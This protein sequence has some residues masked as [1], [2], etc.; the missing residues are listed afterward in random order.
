MTQV[1]RNTR[2]R[3]KKREFLSSTARAGSEP[4]HLV[5]WGIAGGAP[6]LFWRFEWEL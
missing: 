2:V 5:F 1:E 6:S 3:A 4:Q